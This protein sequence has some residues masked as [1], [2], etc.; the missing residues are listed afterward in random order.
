MS[1]LR[2]GIALG[3]AAAS[4]AVAILIVG[5]RGEGETAPFDATQV[6][7]CVA[8]F[9]APTD[10]GRAADCRIAAERIAGVDAPELEPLYTRL[11][12]GLA[13]TEGLAGA[14]LSSPLRRRAYDAATIRYGRAA[15]GAADAALAYA[16]N[17]IL[18]GRCDR[19]TDTPL[20]LL[21]EA[22]QGFSARAADDPSRNVGLR[23]AAQAW[24]DAL[25]FAQ[26]AATLDTLG[27]DAPGDRAQI[28]RWRARA[29]DVD[30]AVAAFTSALSRP[31]DIDDPSWDGRARLRAEAAL[32]TI[33]FRNGDIDEI[34]RLETEGV[35]RPS[36]G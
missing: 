17:A 3:A 16:Q 36:D 19:P 24:A 34:R 27:T 9:A 15:S 13:A 7:A 21:D 26:A 10:Q 23:A 22:T 33:L 30:G 11:A 8:A 12:D 25:A 5:G 2:W 6:A 14:A 1:I 18:L 31:A 32:R 29:G 4:G 35:L 20:Q 28:A